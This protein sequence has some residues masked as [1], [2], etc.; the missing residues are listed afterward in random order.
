ME[1]D[2]IF[3]LNDVC[4]DYIGKDRAL[5]NINMTIERGECVSVL[6]A[7][8]SGKSTLLKLLDGLYFCSKGELFGFNEKIDESI[9]ADKQT[10]R[11]FHKKVGFVFQ[12]PDVQL[13][14]PT[15]WDEVAFAPLQM[16]LPRRDVA[17]IA[18]D[19]LDQLG[20]FGLKDRAP[21]H[22][23]EGEK[24]KV[25]I[26]SVLTL[27]PD[28]WLMDEPT[29]SLD[30]RSQGWVI[31]FIL[32]LGQR[33]KTAVIATHDLEIPYVAT[34]D[35]YVLGQDHGVL[36]HGPSSEI[37]ENDEILLSANLIHRHRHIHRGAAHSHP[38]KHW[39]S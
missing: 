3:K 22:L 36:A 37:L 6:G 35:C 38:H 39:H 7:N 2:N 15:V 1:K 9:M 28:V 18:S 29:A 26:A 8:G 14:L 30:P 24:K 11:A 32:E 21:Y 16:G 12:D 31:D 20:L 23:S 5:N 27:D 10:A 4:Y 25:S 19:A 17:E 34:K 13:F 33:K